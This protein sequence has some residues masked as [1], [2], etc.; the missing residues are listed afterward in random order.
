MNRRHRWI[1]L[2]SLSL[3]LLLTMGCGLCTLTGIRPP[4]RAATEIAA[5]PTP[6]ST[7]MPE[8][9]ASRGL[10]EQSLIALYKKVNPSVVSIQVIR[11]AQALFKS[12]NKDIE[13]QRGQGSGFIVDGIKG[14]VV[15]NNHVVENVQVVQVVLWD[16]D[17]LTA[18]VLGQDSDSDTAVL[19]VD[20][21][22]RELQE[23][24]LGDSDALQVGQDA[25]AIGNPFG[26]EGTLTT[27]IISG[28]GRTLHMGHVSERVSGRF[29]IP[30]MI[31][32]DAAINFGN[33][34][35]PLLDSSGRVIGMNSAIDAS[36]GASSGVGFAVPI[37]TIKHV[38]PDLIEKGHHD[39]AWLGISGGDLSP[40]HVQAM[41]LPVERGAIIGAVV[42]DGPAAKAGLQGADSTVDYFGQEIRIGGDVVIAI[43]EVPVHQFDDLLI[44]LMREKRPG[45]TALLTIIRDGQEMQLGVT[46]GNRPT[47]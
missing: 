37:N 20:A 2:V 25:V 26:W 23:V 9:V 7:R 4:T 17:V 46:L 29:S 33:S 27:G 42:P 45:D 1:I 39:Y 30:E 32:T 47:D 14:L 28:V 3:I 38:M 8:A 36:G 5:K 41:Q 44:Y 40:I 11:E 24:T 6:V 12:E 43:D 34:G 31:Q 21:E 19:Q 22:G 10:G 15:T 13:Y 18:K 35:G 16:G